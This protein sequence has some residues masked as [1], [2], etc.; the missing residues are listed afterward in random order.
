MVRVQSKSSFHHEEGPSSFSVPLLILSLVLWS[1]TVNADD[2][3]TMAS[4]LPLPLLIQKIRAADEGPTDSQ[5]LRG[6]IVQGSADD[7]MGGG[8]NPRLFSTLQR[9]LPDGLEE[10]EGFVVRRNDNVG[11]AALSNLISQRKRSGSSSGSITSRFVRT[12]P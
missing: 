3:D 8:R 6:L 11:L 10:L 12:S 1:S 9:G 4:R 2:L 7:G 5:S